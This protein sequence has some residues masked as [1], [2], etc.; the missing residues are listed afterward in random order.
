[1]TDSISSLEEDRAKGLC[2]IGYLNMLMTP[3]PAIGAWLAGLS[4]W[5]F[6]AM[7][8]LIA[9]LTIGLQRQGGATGRIA[10]AL[11]VM[12]QLPLLTAALAGHAWQLDTHLIYFAVLAVLVILQDPRPLL[13]ASGIVIVHHVMLTLLLPTLIYPSSGLLVDLSRLTLHGTVWVA[14]TAGLYYLL[15]TQLRQRQQIEAETDRL[16]EALS[17]SHDLQTNLGRKDKEQIAIVEQVIAALTRLARGDLTARLDTPFP[18]QFEPLRTEFNSAVRSLSIAMA[19]VQDNTASIRTDTG[20]IAA[21]T[22]KL[23]Q[24]TEDQA[25]ALSSVTTRIDQI[26]QL[27]AIASDNA[28]QVATTTASTRDDAESGMAVVD[29]ALDAMLNIKS[30]T[31]RILS[32]IGLIEDV[33][34]QTNLL[35]L[36]AGV[37]AARAGEAG[38]GFAVVATEVRALA[39]RS[40]DAAQ[41]ISGLISDSARHVKAGVDLMDNAGAVLRDVLEA[42][43]RAS[44]AMEGI[45]ASVGTQSGDIADLKSTMGDLDRLTQE[46]AAMF[47]ET[48]AA[49]T[50]LTDATD[51]LSQVVAEFRN[52]LGHGETEGVRQNA[53]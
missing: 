53:A 5:P 37:E 51:L 19:N 39:G 9:A 40:S 36:N 35:A 23:A 18:E 17:R 52:G 48:S 8:L 45:A 11:G 15:M 13:A 12:G 3:V 38:Q 20:S 22:E 16:S 30:S 29:G 24:R 7:S 42:V 33:A 41:E 31:D 47:E 43:R 46:N 50:A 1:M 49:T 28:R 27:M 10:V 21:A 34:L 4:P 44:D 32:V 2:L 26:S 25:H 14:E 6:L